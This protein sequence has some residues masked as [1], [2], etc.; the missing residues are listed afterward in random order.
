MAIDLDALW[1]YGNP[2]VSEQRFT[3]A[4]NGASSDDAFL[5][6]TQIARTY[7]LRGQFERQRDVLAALK[8]LLEGASAE[9]RARYHLELGRSYASATHKPA[10]Q[11]AETRALAT[12]AFGEAILAAQAGQLDG[13]LVDAL[14]MMEFAETSA[15]ARLRWVREAL[16]V[17][18]ASTQ[19]AA[20]R[21]E[22]SL[23]NNLGYALHNL[24]RYDEAL[25]EFEAALKLR[26]AQGQPEGI[27]IARWMVAWTL[28]SLGRHTEALAIQLRLEHERAEAKRPSPYVFGELAELYRLLGDADKSRHYAALKQQ[29]EAP[30]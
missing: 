12:A 18:S 15:D 25:K 8:P 5:L 19:P 10:D 20:R 4:L 9:A 7:G 2:A 1:D 30:R 29:L 28:R 16:A 6:R 23:R 22:A 17:S 13:L 27:R 26:E 3:A 21:W 11:T 14:H 24:G